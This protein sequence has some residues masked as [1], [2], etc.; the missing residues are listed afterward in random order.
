[1]PAPT[2]G[3][4]VAPR[5]MPCQWLE[6]NGQFWILVLEA[7]FVAPPY[8]PESCEGAKGPTLS[9]VQKVLAG[10]LEKLAKAAAP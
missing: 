6:K 1:M 5:R 10:E 4:P 3:L 2:R 9:R 8:T 7:I